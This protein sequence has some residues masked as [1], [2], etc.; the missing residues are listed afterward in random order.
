MPTGLQVFDATGRIMLDTTTRLGRIYSTF[1]SGVADGAV[2][3]SALA[4]GGEPF[5]FVE[6]NSA[7]LTIA[8]PYAY[9]NVTVSGTTVSW[10]FVDFSYPTAGN[11]V[12]RRAVN[13]S[14]GTF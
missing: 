14:A 13:I 11:L 2:S 3:V 5:V 9:P 10:S 1:S 8:T 12:P 6:D 4:D 7:D